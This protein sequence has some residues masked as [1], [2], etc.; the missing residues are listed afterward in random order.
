[1]L[2]NNQTEQERGSSSNTGQTRKKLKSDAFW[3]IIGAVG[4]FCTGY[5]I[6]G[7]I[8]SHKFASYDKVLG[9]CREIVDLLKS[10]PEPTEMEKAKIKD[11]KKMV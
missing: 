2:D 7:I 9:Q 6:K 4:W 8:D 10:E 1:M 3:V 11:P 5:N